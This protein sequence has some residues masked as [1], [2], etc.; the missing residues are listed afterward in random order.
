MNLTWTVESP[1]LLVFA[2]EDNGTYIRYERRGDGVWYATSIGRDPVPQSS[3]MAELL[4][5]VAA[6]EVP[7]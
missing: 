3:D 2:N 1:D 4:D 7:A 5:R 6:G